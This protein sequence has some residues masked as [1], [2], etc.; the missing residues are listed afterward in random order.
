MSKRISVNE[1]RSETI[2]WAGRPSGR[3]AVG[4]QPARMRTANRRRRTIPPARDLI[5][6]ANED[7]SWLRATRFAFPG[8]PSGCESRRTAR[9]SG[10]GAAGIH[11]AP[12]IPP[13]TKDY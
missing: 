6:G 2:R 12:Q 13:L 4:E 7:V 10:G 11:P 9:Y 1:G 5:G 3:R 8:F